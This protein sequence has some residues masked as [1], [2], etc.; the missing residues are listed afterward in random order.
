LKQ[1]STTS[2]TPNASITVVPNSQYNY[3]KDQL[4]QAYSGSDAQGGS[5]PGAPLDNTTPDLNYSDGANIGSYSMVDQTYISLDNSEADLALYIQ[6]DIQF[7]MC[8]DW[9]I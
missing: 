3:G 4:P 9:N 5:A 6:G 1:Y 7:G 2:L 8:G